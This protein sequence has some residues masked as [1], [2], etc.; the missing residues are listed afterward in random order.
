M[1]RKPQFAS[2]TTTVKNAAAMFVKYSIS[3]LPVVTENKTLAG[4]VT[5]KDILKH[6]LV[7]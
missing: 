7:N 5:G 6:C 3:C 4:I 2:P 1:T